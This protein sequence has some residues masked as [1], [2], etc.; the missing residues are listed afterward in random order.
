MRTLLSP[1]IQDAKH[2]LLNNDVV[3]IPT[4]TVYGL[5]ANAL[6]EA[7][8]LK[9]FEIKNRPTF[10]P[11]IVHCGR[12][13]DVAYYVEEIPEKLFPLIKAF[14]P[15]PITFLLRKKKII[16]DI[17]TAGSNYVAIRVPNHPI[18]LELLQN[19][20]FPLAAPSANPFGYV[21]PTTAQHVLDNL[22][23]KIPFILNGEKSTVGVESTIV[24]VNENNDVVIYRL[25]G[26]SKE[27]IEKEINEQALILNHNDK[28][29]T[30]GQLKSHY[31]T[32]APLYVGNV[33]ELMQEFIG[34][35]IF[36]I[37]LQKEYNNIPKS[38]QFILSPNADINV[39]AQNLFS[40]LR[41]IDNLQ[42]DVI[43][44][45]IFPV[46]GLGAAIN[47]RLERASAINK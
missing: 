2:H 13:T 3:A 14:S 19:L 38:N 36:T 26:I 33:E 15:G 8:V 5:A 47:D 20:P 9:I 27:Y 34:K 37:S 4:E 41:K 28:P 24:G 10:N 43:L 23:G 22:N 25:G 16:P 46:E 40:A 12:W 1:N 30:S 6:N 44:A 17:V 42:P 45:E 32:N 21:S 39:A 11:L 31:A 35:N 29:T 7:A 18:T